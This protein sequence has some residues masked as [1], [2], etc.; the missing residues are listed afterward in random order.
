MSQT[1]HSLNIEFSDNNTLTNLFGINDKN[2][3]TLEKINNVKIQYRGNKVKIVGSKKSIN[4]TKEELMSLFNEAKKGIEIN[5]DKIK[6]TKSMI[7]L[8]ID[9]NEQTDLFFQTKKTKL[10]KMQRD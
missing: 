10:L 5:E 8:E 6:E 9:K 2:I 4:D 3:Q 1:N 7:T